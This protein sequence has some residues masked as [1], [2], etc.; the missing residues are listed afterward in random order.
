MDL[1]VDEPQ[2]SRFQSEYIRGI[3]YFSADILHKPEAILLRIWGVGHRNIPTIAGHSFI[4][5]KLGT[6]R[7]LANF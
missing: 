5:R 3:R 1:D 4:L 7:E 6:V 2:Y